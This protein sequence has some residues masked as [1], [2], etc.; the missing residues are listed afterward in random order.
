MARESEEILLESGE[1]SSE[2]VIGNL[3][4]VYPS[5]EASDG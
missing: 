4:K 3:I 2:G 5:L 1:R